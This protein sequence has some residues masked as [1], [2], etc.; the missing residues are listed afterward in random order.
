[1]AADLASTESAK[2]DNRYSSPAPEQAPSCPRPAHPRS[3]RARGPAGRPE[4][5]PPRADGRKT[6]TVCCL[7]IGQ[8]AARAQ[9]TWVREWIVAY[10]TLIDRSILAG[11]VIKGIVRRKEPSAWSNLSRRRRRHYL[12]SIPQRLG[13]S[14]D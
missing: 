12:I 5:D 3:A 8:M 11:W 10:I 7:A 2:S 1:M 9:T 13:M 14:I 6:R 4:A